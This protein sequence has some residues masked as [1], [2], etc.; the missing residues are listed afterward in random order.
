MKQSS[1]NVVVTPNSACG[2]PSSHCYSTFTSYIIAIYYHTWEVGLKR[3]LNHWRLQLVL[4]HTCKLW[5]M[6]TADQPCQFHS[7]PKSNDIEKHAG[8][9]VAVDAIDGCH[10]SP[11]TLLGG[12]DDHWDDIVLLRH[13]VCRSLCFSTRLVI[14]I[15][16]FNYFI[17]LFSYSLTLFSWT[18]RTGRGFAF[19]DPSSGKTCG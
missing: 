9:C 3:Q 8:L 10:G 2:Q 15:M 18:F 13:S 16:T 4:Y 5:R 12:A 19:P 1:L 17:Q 6:E 14:W 11:N 7:I